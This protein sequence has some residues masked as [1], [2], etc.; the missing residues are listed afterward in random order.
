MWNLPETC[1][2]VGMLIRLM[3]L[4]INLTTLW[5]SCI[6]LLPHCSNTSGAF[7]ISTYPL[8]TLDSESYI[9]YST[10]TEVQGG[11]TWFIWSSKDTVRTSVEYLYLSL[12]LGSTHHTSLGTLWDTKPD[13]M[14]QEL[15]PA[16]GI[17]NDALFLK[18][19]LD[20]F[21]RFLL[22]IQHIVLLR[23]STISK[24]F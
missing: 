24:N 2:T 8:S 7:F 3:D 20:Q 10:K 16:Q 22:D 1:I 15:W 14:A 21:M 17:F 18:E 19:V 5:Q 12:P 6:S 11:Q 9:F 23:P 4:Y 13:S